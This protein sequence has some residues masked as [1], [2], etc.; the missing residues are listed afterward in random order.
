MCAVWFG[1]VLEWTRIQKYL[2]I[3]FQNAL[4]TNTKQRSGRLEGSL[5]LRQLLPQPI[6][7][8]RLMLLL[9]LMRCLSIKNSEISEKCC[10]TQ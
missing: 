6:Q 1:A 5:L 2:N 9:Q 3:L 4:L 7:H 10:K 8:A